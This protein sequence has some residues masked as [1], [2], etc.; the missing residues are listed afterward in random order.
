MDPQISDENRKL[1]KRI[2]ILWL[3]SRCRETAMSDT[4]ATLE[5]Q[6][7]SSVADDGLSAAEPHEAKERDPKVFKKIRDLLLKSTNRSP[8]GSWLA[9][10]VLVG[11]I[12]VGSLCSR[13]QPVVEKSNAPTPSSA[14]LRPS[15]TAAPLPLLSQ[16]PTQEGTFDISRREHIPC[17]K[18]TDCE[19]GACGSVGY[20]MTMCC[21]SGL[22]VFWPLNG[23]SHYR[24]CIHQ[25]IGS[26]CAALSDFCQS[27]GICNSGICQ[28]EK[29]MDGQSCEDNKNCV[30]GVCVRGLCAAELVQ[31]GG[32]CD[33]DQDCHN[34]LSCALESSIQG[35]KTTCC[36]AE[37]V[38]PPL[39]MLVCKG[40]SVGARC[41]ISDSVCASGACSRGFCLA[42]KQP[43]GAPCE[44]N[45]HCWSN[46]STC[47]HGIC[48]KGLVDPGEFCD[49]DQDCAKGN[50]CALKT[51]ATG[52]DDRVCCRSGG[53]TYLWAPVSNTVCT[54]QVAGS[55]CGGSKSGSLCSSGECIDGFCK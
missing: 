22:S 49:D 48:T 2:G 31:E 24:A 18:D 3:G 20:N 6:A 46:N 8:I 34:G 43:M 4:F 51:L 12:T 39:S 1:H 28:S 27:P 33:D 11:G 52:N 42:E 19:S 17:Q 26:P 50:P 55:L 38:G 30:T 32:A 47:V 29:L 9:I 14:P 25:P 16:T 7:S 21:P 44:S 54:G 36:P 35:D 10:L 5:E 41:G 53:S 13:G 40:Q 15:P 23:P 37:F 45:S